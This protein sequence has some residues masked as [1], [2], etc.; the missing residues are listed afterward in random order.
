M[1]DQELADRVFVAVAELNAARKAAIDGGLKVTIKGPL[2][3]A[4]DSPFVAHVERRIEFERMQAFARV[5]FDQYRHG[6]F[7]RYERKSDG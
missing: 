1:T 4:D 7:D 6:G 3:A 5:E 2:H